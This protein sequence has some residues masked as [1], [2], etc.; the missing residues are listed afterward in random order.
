MGNTSNKEIERK[1]LV[2]LLPE[3][4]ENYPHK[5]IRQGYLVITNDGSEVRLRQ[6]GEEYFE[7]VKGTGGKTRFELE[8]EITKYQFDTMWIATEGKRVEKTRYEIPYN[9]R[10]IELDIY[11]GRLEGLSTVEVEFPGES[12]SNEFVLP[13][14]FG[15]EVTE[16]KEYKNQSLALYGLP[17]TRK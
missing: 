14:W 8:I 15:R 5:S 11:Y 4:L 17:K 16:E 1:F 2:K 6:K 7:T 9:N 10:T 13:E 12:E 3:N